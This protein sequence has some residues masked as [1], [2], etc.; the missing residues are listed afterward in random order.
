MSG[1]ASRTVLKSANLLGFAGTVAVNVLANALPLGGMNT[2][3]LSAL[4]PNLFVPAG[5][6]FSI[7][8]LIYILLGMFVVY[9]ARDLFRRDRSAMPFLEGVGWLFPL[10]SLANMGWIFA[11]HYQRVALS[12]VIMLV[13][14]ASLIAIYLRLGIGAGGAPTSV[15][16]F[17]HAPFSVYLG[18]ITVAT[19]ANATALLVKTGWDGFGLSQ[20]FWTVVMLLAASAITLLVLLKRNDVLFAAVVLWAFAGILIRRSADAVPIPQVLIA[21]GLCM[22]AVLA[23]LLLRIGRWLRPQKEAAG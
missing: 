23:T 5:L 10:A 3:E 18:W 6:T 4:Y 11:W 22:A 20:V 2:G 12:L 8:G 21:L 1:Q 9:Q 17:V 16:V 19:I 7:W 14:L 13:L 15:R